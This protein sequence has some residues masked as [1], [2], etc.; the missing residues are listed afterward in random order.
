MTTRS[1]RLAPVRRSLRNRA[2]IA[3]LGA[4]AAVVPLAHGAQAAGDWNP[5]K[6]D[7]DTV[8]NCITQQPAPGVSAD[9]GWRSETGQV[10]KVG[11]VF[12]VRG[13]AGLVSIP[14]SGAVTVLP[15]LMLPSGVVPA[16]DK[17]PLYWDLTKSGT[18]Q[19]LKTDTLTFDRGANGGF[20]IGT[21]DR[22]AW[23]LRVGDI[24]E[25]QVPVVATRE[26]KGP[27]TQQPECQTRIDGTAPCPAD[28]SG[29]HLQVAFTVGGHGGNKHYVTPYVGLFATGAATGPAG[30]TP[31][32]T[33]A[34]STTKAS[35]RVA[36][37]KA[38]ITI[39]STAA[40]SGKVVITDKGRKIASTQVS[41]RVT[42]LKLPRLRKGK[43][44]LVARYGGSEQVLASSSAPTKVTVR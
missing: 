32:A 34:A 25:I 20:L 24:L 12:Y 36:K 6:H 22:K 5:G 30:P 38:T 43:H 33:Q 8:I 37:R 39:T 40:V 21:P 15:E 44:V 18:P 17:A 11:E 29:D 28:V 9:V 7:E 35:Y 42:T 3:L 41:G 31:G 4:L 16:D 26:L 1:A 14:C 27:A 23:E 13:Y 10:P 19:A 2:G